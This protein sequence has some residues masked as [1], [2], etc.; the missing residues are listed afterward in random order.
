M[1]NLTPNSSGALQ[2]SLESSVSF[3]IIIEFDYLFF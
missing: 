3:I 2:D 1:E